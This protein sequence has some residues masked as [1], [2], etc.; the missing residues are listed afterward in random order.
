M[1]IQLDICPG[2]YPLAV[3]RVY[4]VT[5]PPAASFILAVAMDFRMKCAHVVGRLLPSARIIPL[6]TRM[7]VLGS[8]AL[9]AFSHAAL[10]DMV[11]ISGLAH[12]NVCTLSSGKRCCTNLH[13]SSDG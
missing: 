6:S 10:G 9:I 1:A 7:I 2:S 3:E 12:P 13:H 11:T 5:A 4:T 8:K